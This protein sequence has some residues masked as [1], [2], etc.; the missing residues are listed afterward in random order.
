MY[1]YAKILHKCFKPI[2]FSIQLLIEK[3]VGT[4]VL[5]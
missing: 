4:G 5:L 2:F 3:M 1:N